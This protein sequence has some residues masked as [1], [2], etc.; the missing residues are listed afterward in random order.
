[1]IVTFIGVPCETF[2]AKRY[3][4][5][6]ISSAGAVLRIILVKLVS[7]DFRALSHDQ[8]VY[9][10][11]ANIANCDNYAQYDPQG[12]GTCAREYVHPV[13]HQYLDRNEQREEHRQIEDEP[14]LLHELCEERENKTC[15]TPRAEQKDLEQHIDAHS[16]EFGH[17]V[18]K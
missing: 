4:V 1:M 8:E 5:L 2:I 11:T 18:T 10:Q 13:E 15:R 3:T 7:I 6:A 12:D 14:S 9:Q 16:R 17:A